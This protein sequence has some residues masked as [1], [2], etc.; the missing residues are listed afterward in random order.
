M[1]TSIFTV[2]M[3]SIQGN[4]VSDTNAGHFNSVTASPIN[5]TENF[6]NKETVTV[7][8]YSCTSLINTC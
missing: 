7:L 8:S 1:L 3:S 6:I 2:D 5:N 4:N